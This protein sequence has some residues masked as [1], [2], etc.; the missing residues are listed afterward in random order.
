MRLQEVSQEAFWHLNFLNVTDCVFCVGCN[1]D[2]QSFEPWFWLSTHHWKS[3]PCSLACKL[4]ETTSELPWW[5]SKMRRRVWV[6]NWRLAGRHRNS[7]KEAFERWGSLL[8]APV[9]TGGARRSI[10]LLISDP[11]ALEEVLSHLSVQHLRWSK[12]IQTLTCYRK[13]LATNNWTRS[14]LG[15]ASCCPKPDQ[16]HLRAGARTPRRTGSNVRMFRLWTISGPNSAHISLL[17]DSFGVLQGPAHSQSYL[18]SAG[19]VCTFVASSAW[20]LFGASRWKQ[21]RTTKIS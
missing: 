15:K 21:W 18:H 1:L 17:L 8:H 11:M 14:L 20:W 6:P 4:K 12:E 9:E 3:I 2:A 19:G 10:M 5:W 13:G 16:D 7:W